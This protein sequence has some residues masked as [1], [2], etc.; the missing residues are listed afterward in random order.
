[1]APEE[2]LDHRLGVVE[3]GVLLVGP[4]PRDQTRGEVARIPV[5]EGQA[6]PGP[7]LR[8]IDVDRILEIGSR[9]GEQLIAL[10][11][12]RALEEQ[13]Q[14]VAQRPPRL[15]RSGISGR[16]RQCPL[17]VLEPRPGG[18]DARL[19]IV[20]VLVLGDRGRKRHARSHR[21]GGDPRRVGS[22]RYGERRVG[23]RERR[24]L[25]VGV[26]PLPRRL[27]VPYQAPGSLDERPRIETRRLAT[28]LPDLDLRPQT[29]SEESRDGDG[30]RVLGP[31]ELIARHI[32]SGGVDLYTAVAVDQPGRDPNL[33]A[34]GLDASGDHVSDVQDAGDAVDSE[35][36]LP[37]RLDAVSGDDVESAH[38][39]E[40]IDQSAREPVGCERVVAIRIL[41]IENRHAVRIEPDLAGDVDLRL[42]LSPVVADDDGRR[43]DR[44]HEQ[45]GLKPDLGALEILLALLAVIPRQHHRAGDT[46]QVE[47][48]GDPVRQDR[49]E[50]VPLELRDALEDQKAAGEI[51]ADPRDDPTTLKLFEQSHRV[52]RSCHHQDRAVFRLTESAARR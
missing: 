39:R 31:E 30:E 37:E 3:E 13:P 20:R 49:Q 51:G 50:A 27:G 32:E 16:L 25:G 47:D 36:G 28:R 42:E 8:R 52:S 10:E 1:M 34:A 6:P 21:D 22:L 7:R 35:L 2:I 38:A 9:S 48:Q 29:L 33:V 19:P 46:E 12:S 18:L 17:R 24:Q 15:K 45:E 11:R 44:A 40:S 5:D 14:P 4:A 23:G 26:V 41:E 43:G